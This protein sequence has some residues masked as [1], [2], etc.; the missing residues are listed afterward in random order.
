MFGDGFGNAFT[1]ASNNPA[2]VAEEVPCGVWA[3]AVGVPAGVWVSVA[4]G[5]PDCT[6]CS[7]DWAVFA[8]R[9]WSPTGAFAYCQVVLAYWAVKPLRP[10]SFSL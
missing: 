6:P 2:G 10:H 1:N 4:P 3:G 5:W 9:P 8:E 7:P